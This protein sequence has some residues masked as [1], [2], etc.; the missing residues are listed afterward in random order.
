M[1]Y[2]LFLIAILFS[3]QLSAQELSRFKVTCNE[4]R[5]NAPV[6]ISLNGINYNTDKGSLVLYEVLGKEKRAIVPC[7]L[8]TGHSARLWFLLSGESK[9]GEKRE[10]IL[11]LEEL[12]SNPEIDVILKKDN[13]DLAL[14][15]GDNPILKY[16]YASEYWRRIFRVY[17]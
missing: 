8:E 12:A 2:L 13:E 14:M 15:S 1:R 4:K 16:R 9:K 7:Q 3:I 11:M 5:I 17:D 6:S 10:F